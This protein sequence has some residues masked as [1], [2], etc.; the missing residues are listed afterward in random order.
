MW[1]LGPGQFR[2]QRVVHGDHDGLCGM[3]QATA[4]AIMRVQITHAPAAAVE[5]DEGRGFHGRDVRTIAPQADRTLVG[6]GDQIA[7]LGHVQDGATHTLAKQLVPAAQGTQILLHGQG[8]VGFAQFLHEFL[9][10][11][12]ILEEFG[13]LGVHVGEHQSVV[14]GLMTSSPAA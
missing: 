12:P 7:H 13:Q 11:Q 3:R 2:G 1:R 8:G 6:V 14:H 5:V 10:G 4:D 9:L